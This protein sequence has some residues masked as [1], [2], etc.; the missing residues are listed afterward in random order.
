[1]EERKLVLINRQIEKSDEA[2]CIAELALNNEKI[3]T[4][5]NRIYYAV[6]YTVTALAIKHDFIT[7]K[8]KSLIGW[9]NKIFVFENKVFDHKL[10]EIFKD[11][12]NRRQENDYEYEP[13]LPTLDEI[14]TYLAEAKEFIEIV[15]KEIFKP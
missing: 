6:F 10:Y 14:R 13:E 7:S 1:M 4:A 9:F 5:Q 15:R 8:H 12:F 3:Y 11:S 2:L